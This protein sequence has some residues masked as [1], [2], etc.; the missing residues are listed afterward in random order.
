MG[1]LDQLQTQGGSNLSN[2][3]G[4]TPSTPEFAQSKLH[5]TYSVDGA[6]RLSGKPAP[7]NLESGNPVKYLDN[8]PR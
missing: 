1:L 2:L 5:D 6:P 8:L 4:R 3:N 7:S